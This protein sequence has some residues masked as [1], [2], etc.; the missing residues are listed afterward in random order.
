M[1]KRVNLQDNIFI[2]NNRLRILRDTLT[3]DLDPALFMEK[4]IEDTEFLD[5][6]LETLLEYLQAHDRLFERDEVLDYLSDLEWDFSLFLT[7]LSGSPGNISAVLY[8][9]LQERI[10]L[11]RSRGAARL[12]VIGENRKAV[13]VPST[14]NTVSSDELNELLKDF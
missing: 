11:L 7:D 6:A 12:K 2:L 9:V 14:E 4:T 3:L 1:D 8:P 10:G 5:R 13:A